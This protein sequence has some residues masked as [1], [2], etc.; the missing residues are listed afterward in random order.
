MSTEIVTNLT[1]AVD[2]NGFFST[3]TDTSQAGRIKV[4]NAVN[5]ANSISEEMEKSKD[6]SLSVTVSDIIVQT[7][8]VQNETTGEFEKNPRVILIDDKG[9]AHAAISKG[10]FSACRNIMA[11]LGAP[12]TWES[13]ITFRIFEKRGRNGYRF[14]TCEIAD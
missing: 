13:P 1:S 12:S 5:S 4:F 9:V 8:D 7:V 2:T 3:V 10:L 14:M 11:F 6:G